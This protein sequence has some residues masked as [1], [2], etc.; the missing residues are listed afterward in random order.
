M[1]IRHWSLLI[2]LSGFCNPL[3]AQ[4]SENFVVI[5]PAPETKTGSADSNQAIS[6][7]AADLLMAMG[8]Y[9]E[10]ADMYS[11]LIEQF[12]LLNDTANLDRA[13]T[14]LYRAQLSLKTTSKYKD[15][16]AKC[17]PELID[18]FVG[19]KEWDPMFI[20]QPEFIP[21]VTWLNTATPGE[22]Y[23]VTVQFDIDEY[24]NAY[25]FDFDADDEMYL[26]YPVIDSLKKTRFLPAIKNGKA[27]NKPKN[28]V[29]VV[30][31]LDR[32]SSCAQDN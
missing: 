23:K 8:C 25:N 17:R 20:T 18:P 11:L 29:E 10:A 3:Y 4:L 21:D 2:L 13:C 9:R 12:K 22:I 24:G 5:S 16:I 7:N 15:Q 1:A 19:K 32:G 27:I 6:C 30:F 31:C 28:I 26:R 14:G